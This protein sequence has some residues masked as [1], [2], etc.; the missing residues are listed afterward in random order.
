MR[1]EIVKSLI[2]LENYVSI[3]MTNFKLSSGKKN[4]ESL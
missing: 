1:N 4:D 3:P 2:F